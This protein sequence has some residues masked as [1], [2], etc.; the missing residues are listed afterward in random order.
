[1]TVES[2]GYITYEAKNG[3][4]TPVGRTFTGLETLT[5]KG[6]AYI[7]TESAGT[8]EPIN[9]PKAK[10]FMDADSRIYLKPNVVMTVKK[11]FIGGKQMPAGEYTS[12]NLP[13][14][15]NPTASY[16]GGVLKVLKGPEGIV[17]VVR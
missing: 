11:L 13:Q 2:G 9:S 10:L 15:D 17:L 16:N 5:L 3:K 12:E 8:V 14:M 6:A 7:R 4:T 1:M